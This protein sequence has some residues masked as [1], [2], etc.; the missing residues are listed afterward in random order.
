MEVHK[1]NVTEL[2]DKRNAKEYEWFRTALITISTVFGLVISLKTKKSTSPMEHKMFVSTM[3]LFGVTIL[4]GLIFLY[5]EA[6]TPHKLLNQYL[7]KLNHGETNISVFAGPGKLFT[8][9]R[10]TFF[11]LTILSFASLI[12]YVIY[13]DI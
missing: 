12:V 2:A 13:A 5:G 3:I 6:L 9:L 4:N 11:L 10:Y 8:L 7:D 1:K